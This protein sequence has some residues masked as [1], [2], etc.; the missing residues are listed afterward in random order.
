VN[1]ERGTIPNPFDRKNMKRLLITIDGPAGAG[2][3]TVSREVARRLG[4]NY[5]DT[6]ALY[7][8]VALAVQNEKCQPEDD[9]RIRNI[10]ETLSLRFENI[11]TGLRLLM[12]EVDIT[13]QIRTQ[14]ITM[15]ASALSAKAVVREHLLRVQREL[16]RDG[17]VVFE[18]RDMGTV[19]FPE[20]NVKFFLDADL[21]VRASR[22]QKELLHKGDGIDLEEV[23]RTI[24]KRDHDDSRRALAPLKP[25]KDA[26][27]I[28][29]ST[30]GIDEVVGIILDCI[31]RAHK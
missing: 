3:T 11:P 30:L 8:G 4:Y 31:N 13:D 28:N 26:I 20:A 23:E 25:A 29:S 12:N 24:K 19:V 18:G 10:C 21:D 9:K 7:R 6:G 16:G 1:S 14:E 2:K 27:R 22:R 15:L 17:G 5:V